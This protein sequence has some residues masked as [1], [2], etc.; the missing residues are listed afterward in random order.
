MKSVP[1]PTV[2]LHA[3]DPQLAHGFVSN[4]KRVKKTDKYRCTEYPAGLL[5]RDKQQTV[6]EQ[7]EQQVLIKHFQSDIMESCA[8]HQ[9]QPV[10]LLSWNLANGNNFE[11]LDLALQTEESWNTRTVAIAVTQI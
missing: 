4:S 8:C 2:A 5:N 10:L 3:K 9:R 1:H 11:L 6:E 7:W